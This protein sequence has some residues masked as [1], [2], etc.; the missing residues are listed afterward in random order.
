MSHNTRIQAVRILPTVQASVEHVELGLYNDS[1]LVN[2]AASSS[3]VSPV[4]PDDISKFYIGQL[5]TFS[6]GFGPGGHTVTNITGSPL[7]LVMDTA[8]TS[9]HTG[10]TATGQ[11]EIRWSENPLTVSV[12]SSVPQRWASGIIA[13][14]GIG[15][16]MEKA[17][18]ARGGAAVAFDGTT[19]T[20]VD[21]NQMLLRLNELGIKLPG[22]ICEVWEFVGTE[23][24]SAAVEAKKLATFSIEDPSWSETILSIPVKNNVF[25]RRAQ[26]GTVINNDPISGNYPLAADD[27]NGQIVPISF[28]EFRPRAGTGPNIYA[29]FMRV[30][31]WD[32]VNTIQDSNWKVLAGLNTNDIS[33]RLDANSSY[34]DPQGADIFPVVGITTLTTPN[35]IYKIKFGT[36]SHGFNPPGPGGTFH[37]TTYA[38][39]FF[40]GK[41]VKVISASQSD[42]QKSIGKMRKISSSSAVESGDNTVVDITLETYFEADIY[43]RSSGGPSNTWLDDNP[44]T[45][46][47]IID[48]PFSYVADA[49]PCL[50]F[51]DQDGN[52]LTQGASVFVF[53]SGVKQI[54][55]PPAAANQEIDL[56]GGAETVTLQPVNPTPQGFLQIPPYGFQIG[57]LP[58]QA[59]LGNGFVF[60]LKQFR[61]DPS[62]VL[63]F[64]IFP[65]LNLQKYLASDLAVFSRGTAQQKLTGDCLYSGT[66]FNTPA[67]GCTLSNPANASNRDGASY[68][69]CNYSLYDSVTNPAIDTWCALDFDLPLSR[70]LHEY[71]AYYIGINMSSFLDWL[72]AT[73]SSRHFFLA[74]RRFMGVAQY[75]NATT[76]ANGDGYVDGKEGSG[77]TTWKNINTLP[78][79]YYQSNA[80]ATN[81]QFFYVQFLSG[82]LMNGY[83]L[84]ALDGFK[85]VDNLKSISKMSILKDV[86]SSVGGAYTQQIRFNKLAL[87]CELSSDIS[88]ALYSI[89]SGRIFN[90]TWGSR[91][92]ATTLMTNPIDI[93]EHVCRSQNWAEV[94]DLVVYGKQYCQNAKIK[95]SGAGSFD[96]SSLAAI[97]ALSPVF[98]IT[99]EKKGWTDSIKSDLCK[100]Y[101]LISRQ[102]EQGF[103]CVHYIDPQLSDSSTPDTMVTFKDMLGQVGDTT[104]PKTEDVFVEP[105]VNYSYNPGTNQYDCQLR[106]LNSSDSEWIGTGTLASPQFAAGS[107]WQPVYTPGFQGTDGEA[108]WNS[109]NAL[110]TRFRTLITP[111]SDMTDCKEVVL[112]SDALKFITDWVAWMPLRRTSFTVPYVLVPADGSGTPGAGV[113]ARDWYVGKKILFNNPHKTNGWSI[114]VLVEGIEKNKNSNSIK[115][116]IVL[117]QDI[118][119]AFFLA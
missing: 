84:Y 86:I 11:T 90:D 37:G 78:D 100:R 109:C 7:A 15:P 40:A 70:L 43:Q 50:G 68:A 116:D 49:S 67:G 106:V 92:T 44:Q 104:E 71:D 59:N 24:N 80:P 1:A 63:S 73:T 20:V 101:F 5:L 47:A 89:F 75:A 95:T 72:N 111:P 108:I 97:K 18:L 53:N 51:E 113:P 74:W 115:V 22:L 38:N 56:T 69:V 82:S 112:Y 119:T 62:R 23:A 36:T 45:W 91:K 55:Q 96:D 57:P 107:G 4:N 94:G 14:K 21:T 60:D 64:D 9:T 102:D 54:Q 32:T 58:G 2:T 103:E 65:C 17:A 41:Y 3:F 42:P 87:I 77:D 88:Q 79:F 29:K 114:K 13:K 33:P 99:E 12:S 25:K 110:W 48:I 81:N 26:M 61:D 39:G 31:E 98:Q 28:G 117:L 105:F 30:A 66:I 10:V 93:F 85:T 35:L 52:A 46:I 8:A 27:K 118:P 6:A 34:C 19:I 16:L 76:L 83:Q